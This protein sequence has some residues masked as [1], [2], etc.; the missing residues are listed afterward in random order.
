MTTYSEIIGGAR[1][2]QGVLDTSVMADDLVSTGHRLADAAKAGNWHEVMH[3]L[4]REWNWLVINQWRP[5]GT[6]W[7]TALHQ[8]AWHG[9]PPEVVTEL[10][11]RGSLRSLRDSKGR[12][13]FDVA[14]ERNPVPVLLELLRPPRSPLTSE[15]IRALDTRLAELIDGR[16]RG[17][18]F[19]GDLR[20]A[21]RYPPVEVLHEPPG[22]R[23]CVPLPGKYVFHVEL[24][25]GALEVKSW[26][27]FVEG[28]GQA[29]LVTPE[30]SVLVDQGFV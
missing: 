1:P 19:D 15:Q 16:I 17:R 5:G 11:D 30:G 7:F 18:V 22:Q 24:Q 3:V 25:R 9:A 27:G 4:D 10:L 28:S 26:C 23:V 14:I 13:P 20:A 6:A 8:A 2:W 29:H 21:L 12:T